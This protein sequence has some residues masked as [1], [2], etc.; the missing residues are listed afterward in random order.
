MTEFSEEIKKDI[1]RRR[2]NDVTCALLTDEE[3]SQII[4]EEKGG[5]TENKEKQPQNQQKNEA[6]ASSQKKVS[7]N[8]SPDE[9]R[10]IEEWEKF[11]KEIGIQADFSDLEI[12]AKKDG[13][14]RLI[15]IARGIIA[16]ILCAILQSFVLVNKQITD[17]DVVKSVR[18][19]D[20]N[21]AIWV[22]DNVESDEKMRN[23]YPA[24]IV[25][26]GINGITVI[27][28]L[29]MT[30]KFLK[31]NGRNIDV[32]CGTFCTGSSINIGSS[33]DGKPSGATILFYWEAGVIQ[34]TITQFTGSRGESYS[35]SGNNRY[36]G[37]EVVCD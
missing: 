18:K 23:K 34:I 29:L 27:E 24:D 4:E 2:A 26:A 8:S 6:R 12:P 31:E 10:L 21:Y 11:Y 32:Q 14:D 36:G 33:S 20:K 19:P 16:N 1:R 17:L 5:T 7:R 30:L 13:F 28:Y 35:G 3:I 37:R 22:K 15:I 9:S 25:K